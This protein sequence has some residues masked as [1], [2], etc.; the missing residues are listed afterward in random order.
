MPS[1]RKLSYSPEVELLEP[2]DP[3]AILLQ[4]SRIQ[5]LSAAI[6][7]SKANCAVIETDSADNLRVF[8]TEQE[9]ARGS[10][11]GPVPVVYSGNVNLQEAK[12]AG[13]DGVVVSIDDINNAESWIQACQEA[14][15][16]G[17]E[18]IP[19]VCAS[20][21]QFTTIEQAQACIEAINKAIDSPVAILWSCEGELPTMPLTKPRPLLLCSIRAMV[22]ENRIS[23]AA[24]AVKEA[25]FDGGVLRKDCLTAGLDLQIVGSVYKSI[26]GDLKSVKSK[27]FSFRSKNNLNEDAA[28]KWVKYQK[29]VLSSGALGDPNEAVSVMDDST[30]EYQGFA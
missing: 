3:T 1:G 18:P 10:L 28:A 12:E 30:G 19:E 4:T 26:I 9:S 24:T 27:A 14:R 8:C 15:Q 23:Q 22:G 17:L 6:R 16:V 29:S 2:T 25:G 21:G 11:P 20:A 13:A 5:A 7:A